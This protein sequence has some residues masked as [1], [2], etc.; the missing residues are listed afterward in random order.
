MT[1]ITKSI[2]VIAANPGDVSTRMIQLSAV[3]PTSV[4]TLWQAWTDSDRFGEWLTEAKIECAL[5]GAFELYFMP[6]GQPARGS[7]GCTVLC[8]R[9]HA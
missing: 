9:A 1:E 3:F 8:A 7:E 4:T 6:S 2:G 5:G